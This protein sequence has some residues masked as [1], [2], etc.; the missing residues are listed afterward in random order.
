MLPVHTWF[1]RIGLL[2]S[3]DSVFLALARQYSNLSWGVCF[4]F[5]FHLAYSNEHRNLLWKK[6]G[7]SARAEIIGK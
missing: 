5:M 3:T 1:F 4:G 7:C 2:A 6:P